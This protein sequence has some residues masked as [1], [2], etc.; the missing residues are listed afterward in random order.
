MST[1]RTGIQRP[2]DNA[3]HVFDRDDVLDRWYDPDQPSGDN[4][5]PCVDQPC[6]N[7]E[8][9]PL[10][11]SEAPWA[12]AVDPS[13]LTLFAHRPRTPPT[14]T[15]STA[16]PTNPPASQN[17]STSSSTM[18]SA[19]DAIH[20]AFGAVPT[21]KA[22]GSNYRTWLQRVNF[23]ALGCACKTLLSVTTVP[24]G[25]EDEANALLAAIA[26]KLPDSI[27]MNVSSSAA[28]PNDIMSAMKTRFGQTTAVS[29]ANA[30][31]RLFSMRCENEKKMQEHLDRLLALQEEIAEAG[32]TIA[33]KTFTDAVIASVPSSYMSIVQAYES[34]VHVH[35][36]TNPTAAKRAVKSTELLPLLRAEAQ[37]RSSIAR[38]K[39]KEEVA[40]AADSRGKGRGKGKGRRGGKANSGGGSRQSQATSD[41]NITCFKC[42]GKGHRANV[43]PSKQQAKKAP[44]N[45]NVA[46]SSSSSSDSKSSSSTSAKPAAAPTA[47]IVEID[48]GWVADQSIDDAL[49]ASYDTVVE[50]YDSGATNHMT[51]YRHMLTNYRDISERTVRA[52]GKTSFAAC[53][54]GD[55]KVLAPN[56]DSWTRITLS[57]VL[58]APSMSAT[59]VSL[60]RFDDAKLLMQIG[61][62]FLRVMRAGATLC[63]IPKVHGLYRVYHDE[64]SLSAISPGLSL[65][66]LHERL[67]HVSYGYLKKMIKDGAIQGLTLDPNRLDE[68][69]CT[70]C[71]RA[72]AVRK[73][74]ASQR[75]SERAENFGDLLHMDVW[76]PAPVQ[77]V[78]HCRYSLV[79]L[80]DATRW[81]EAPLLHSKDE[82]FAKYV[83]YEARVYNQHGTTIKVVHSDRGGEFTGQDF[84][85]H[86][87][88]QGTVQRLTV[89]DTPEHNGAAERTHGTLLNIIRSLLISSGLPRTMW[90]EAMQHAV[91]LYNRT[92]H[93]GIAFR[94]PY[95]LRFGKPAD[96]TGLHPFGSVCFVKDQDASKLGSRAVEC[97]WL[98]F[99]PTSNGYRVYWPSQRKISVER[100]VTFSSQEIP[101]LEGEDYSLDQLHDDEPAKEQN[102]DDSQPVP[103]LPDKAPQPRR[104]AR[105]RDLYGGSAISGDEADEDLD[106]LEANLAAAHSEMHGYDPQ[107]HHEA[108]RG[109]NSASW[110]E[111]MD[112]EI[113]RLESRDSWEYV[114]APKDANV[115]GSRWVYRTKRDAKNSIT[116]YRARLVGQ[117]FTQVEG[118]DFF[119]DDTFAP[120][121]KMASQRANAA[122]AARRGYCAG[123]KDIK[124]AFLYGRLK[125][126][127]VIYMR[128]PPGVILKGLKPG[129]ILRLKVALYGLKQAGRRWA[130]VL[131]EIIVD[132]GLTRSEHDHAVFYRHLPAEHIAIISS[133]VDDLTLIAPD[134]KMLQRL[135]DKIDARVQATPLQELNWLLGI[136]ISRDLEKRTVSF[137]Q[138]AYIDQILS[139]Y[140]FEDLKPL[141]IPMDPHLQLSQDDCPSTPAD[142]A[143]MRHKPYRE[144]LGALMYAAVATRPDIAYAVSQLARYSANPGMKHWNALRR[145]YAYLKGTRDLA[146]TLGGDDQEPLVGYSDADGMTT[147]GRQAIS[148]YAFLIGGA[149][150][151][152]SKRQEIVAQ[153][154]SEAEYVALSH[155]AK[156]ALW[157]RN[158]LHEVWRMPLDATTI[159][160]DNQSAIAL[161][162]DDRY[163]SRT[164][165][166]DIRFHFIRY[167]VEHGNL[168]VTYCPTEDMVADTLTKAL[169][170]MKAKHFASSLG[171]AKA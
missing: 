163:H 21:L 44:E 121:A 70:V 5:V 56:G 37:S 94:T 4:W 8:H 67:G 18:P 167:H 79:I 95:E 32:I 120:V 9:R 133:H 160:S 143:A 3:P 66:E 137:S 152:S 123:Q 91:W 117:G 162:K 171:L 130:L 168:T 38:S 145:V 33:D 159:Y 7:R 110:Q 26:G 134:Q 98:G 106:V 17:Q 147:E 87:A 141:A 158:Y 151:W 77:T 153:S 139:R 41:D 76:G 73:P 109:P 122:L 84:R 107:T 104:S 49:A 40:A 60:G 128:P 22:D 64:A 80:D 119:S 48:E 72:K 71:M 51:P 57:N 53:G 126:G 118:I 96:L 102:P 54:M 166:I 116:G 142:I 75:S 25:K 148:G 65:H 50:I 113:Q 63:A 11:S 161:A 27:F 165:H 150:S 62:G 36:V 78:N 52:A 24:S 85:D 112:D 146:L 115:I 43:C 164:K 61:G 124:S 140:N 82:A 100:N 155:A 29:E 55:M 144:A 99:D 89:H 170:S 111:A 97:R 81:L 74:I 45:A 105:L 46:Q 129:Q 169:P 154:T 136:E 23:A 47:K 93:A 58:Y 59:L 14:P 131:R 125:D 88:R 114:Y 31:K 35:N 101:L 132:I 127:E 19:V 86:L 157:L 42:S 90:G 149:V 28:L 13:Q 138:R 20:K 156:E 34:S 92:P 108:L 30:Q 103:G 12:I 135:S 68:Q 1:R 83:G 39:P 69:E 15:S 10:G 16:V 6:G 2:C